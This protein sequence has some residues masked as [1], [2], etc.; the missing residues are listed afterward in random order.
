MGV[1]GG[2]GGDAAAAAAAVVVV[3]RWEEGVDFVVWRAGEMGIRGPGLGRFGMVS[4]AFF[5]LRC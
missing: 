2:G 5:P 4:S 3:W 1:G